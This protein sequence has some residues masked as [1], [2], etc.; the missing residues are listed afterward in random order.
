MLIKI[1]GIGMKVVI[2][3]STDLINGGCNACPKVATTSY[4]LEIDGM[5]TPLEDLNVSSLVMA[6]ALKKGYR[7]KLVMDF[8]DEYVIFEK[9]HQQVEVKEDYGVLHYQTIDKMIQTSEK[10]GN[11][12]KLFEK[13]NQVLTKV[14]HL[15]T[16]EFEVI[17]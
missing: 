9:E 17:E 2:S 4:T 10:F 15:A 11:N 7:Q 12:E 5:N 16:V 8:M 3:S 14:F 13:V 6:I 1:G